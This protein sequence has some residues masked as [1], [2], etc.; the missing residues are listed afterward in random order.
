[1]STNGSQRTFEAVE[2]CPR[3]ALQ[4]MQS[5]ADNFLFRIFPRNGL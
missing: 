4:T 1:L 3:A 2:P 5:A